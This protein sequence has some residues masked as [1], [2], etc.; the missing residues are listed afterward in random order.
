MDKEV[1]VSYLTM[2]YLFHHSFQKKKEILPFATWM[3]LKGIRGQ[4]K[5]KYCYDLCKTETNK[6]SKQR[7][8]LC[9]QQADSR[10]WGNWMKVFKSTAFQVQ[11]T[12]EVMDSMMTIVDTAVWPTLKLLR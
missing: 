7:S 3:Q 8:D 6:T 2:E 4:R 5:T 12:R 9:L 1:V 11:S 10:R